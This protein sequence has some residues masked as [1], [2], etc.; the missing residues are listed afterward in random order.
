MK[1]IITNR[2]DFFY[3]FCTLHCD[4]FMQH[5]PKKCAHL[6]FIHLFSFS[7]FD[8][9]YMFRASVVHPQEAS[10]KHI[11]QNRV[12]SCLPDDEPIRFE[13]RRR[14]QKLKI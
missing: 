8:I 14:R 3:V 10:C 2:E 13:T 7:I 12:D 1:K 4:V 5:K 6:K 11:I 9:F